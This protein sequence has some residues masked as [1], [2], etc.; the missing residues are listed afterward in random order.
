MKLVQVPVPNMSRAEVHS[1][2]NIER[3]SGTQFSGYQELAVSRIIFERL[4]GFDL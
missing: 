3:K 1:E 2:D 4:L